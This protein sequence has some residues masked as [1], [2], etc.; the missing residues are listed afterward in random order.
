[1]N[2]SRPKRRQ[3]Y[4]GQDNNVRRA[5]ETELGDLQ[6]VLPFSRRLPVVTFTNPS[7]TYWQLHHRHGAITINEACHTPTYHQALPLCTLFYTAM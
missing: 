4:S 7:S 6:K 2:A 3:V 1:M 5:S